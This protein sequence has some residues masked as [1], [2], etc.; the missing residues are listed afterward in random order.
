MI[1]ISAATGQFGRIALDRLLERV[2]AADVAVAVRDPKKAADM[3]ARGIDVRHGDY[4]DPS[5]LRRAFAGADALLFISSPDIERGQR[6]AQHRRVIDAARDSGVQRIVY[7]SGL[8][9]DVVEEG[10]LGEH[11]ATEL[12]LADSGLPYTVLRNPIYSEFFLNPGLLAAVEAGELTSSTHGR[13]MN[14]ATRAELAEAAAV[15]LT[16]STPAASYDFTG[17]LWTYPELALLLSDISGRPVNYREVEED[18]GFMTMIGGAIRSGAFELQTEDLESV[19]G[20]PPAGP[21]DV[22]AAVVRP[23]AAV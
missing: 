2:P 11:H 18:E 20:R 16:D 10:V 8:G 23:A 3:A 21:R 14:T 17:S 1:I 5:T 12:A 22:L 7:T 9:A 4:N 6:V 15:V 19:L 13:G